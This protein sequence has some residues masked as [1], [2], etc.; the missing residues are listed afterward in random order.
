MAGAGGEVSN[1]AIARSIRNRS[2]SQDMRW[3]GSNEGYPAQKR[4]RET[5]A[6]RGSGGRFNLLP[7]RWGSPSKTGHCST[8]AERGRVRGISFER[9]R[10]G[11][12]NATDFSRNGSRGGEIWP[13]E[14]Q[15]W[16]REEEHRT[17]VASVGGGGV[18]GARGWHG[19]KEGI[20]PVNSRPRWPKTNGWLVRYG[21]RSGGSEV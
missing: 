14:C 17:S 12:S 7:N 19:W 15:R 10:R 18:F 20:Q 1:F 4:P 21:M 2:A 16:S 9:Y 5:E 8:P 3:K 13:G 11:L 6:K